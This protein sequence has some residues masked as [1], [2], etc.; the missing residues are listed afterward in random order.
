MVCHIHIYSKNEHCAEFYLF[1]TMGV[2]PE[3]SG[4]IPVGE[5]RDLGKCLIE[6][7]LFKQIEEL[8]SGFLLVNSVIGRTLQVRKHYF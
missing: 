1:C 6:S 8:L 4:E 7:P 3:P 5:I 2:A